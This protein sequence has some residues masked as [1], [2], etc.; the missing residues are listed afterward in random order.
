MQARLEQ[1]C[2]CLQ[3]S[4]NEFSDEEE[5]EN[6]GN[7]VNVEQYQDAIPDL[8]G[9]DEDNTEEDPAEV[10]RETKRVSALCCPLSPLSCGTSWLQWNV[11]QLL[12]E[13]ADALVCPSRRLHPVKAFAC[14][15]PNHPV[16]YSSSAPVTLLMTR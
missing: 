2:T 13:V 6:A 5:E 8:E 9:G 11:R 16:S 3:G 1:S 10:Q 7:Q 4:D 15:Y 14:K 12:L